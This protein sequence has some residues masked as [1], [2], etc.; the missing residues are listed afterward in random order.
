MFNKIDLFNVVQNSIY[1]K[2]FLNSGVINQEESSIFYH[3]KD[4]INKSL[5]LNNTPSLENLII[6]RNKLM[7]EIDLL[8]NLTVLNIEMNNEIFINKIQ[9]GIIALN[10]KIH[11]LDTLIE[12]NRDI[13]SLPSLSEY[14]FK[15]IK[16]ERISFHDN[17]LNNFRGERGKLNKKFSNL[18]LKF[19]TNTPLETIEDNEFDD[20]LD[21]Q[22]G[23][24]SSFIDLFTR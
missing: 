24:D 23:D 7:E 8:T 18:S 12:Q 9:D 20:P 16:E 3:C 10:L 14:K 19:L 15:E 11:E 4:L 1:L 21:N 17:Y 22:F 5:G 6:E 13:S 2:E